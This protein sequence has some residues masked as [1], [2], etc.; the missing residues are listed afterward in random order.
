VKI[1][2]LTLRTM[3]ALDPSEIERF[4]NEVKDAMILAADKVSWLREIPVLIRVVEQDIDHR[5]GR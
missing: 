1:E 2:I 4:E 5:P 3:D